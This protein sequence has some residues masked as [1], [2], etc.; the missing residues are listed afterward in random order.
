[1]PSHVRLS[2]LDQ[3][4]LCAAVTEVRSCDRDRRAGKPQPLT[5][6]SSPEKVHGPC[7]T[8]RKGKQPL[9]R[10]PWEHH[11]QQPPWF[12]TCSSLPTPGPGACEQSK[13]GA[14]S[15]LKHPSLHEPSSRPFA[16]VR[17]AKRPLFHAVMRGPA[18]RAAA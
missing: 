3:Q 9:S 7:V 10:K 6:W 16:R 14:L 13:R 17:D 1:M 8:G 11:H 5:L 4:P 18:L 15:L 12:H 2:S